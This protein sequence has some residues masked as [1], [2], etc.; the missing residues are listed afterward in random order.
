M[1]SRC[2]KHQAGQHTEV[3][4]GPVRTCS[5]TSRRPDGRS[6]RRR[7]GL[8]CAPAP[9]GQT[10][11][12][13]ARKPKPFRA[14]MRDNSSPRLNSTMPRRGLAPAPSLSGAGRT[15]QGRLRRRLRRKP[16]TE[17]ARQS[18]SSQLSGAGAGLSQEGLAGQP[19]L[20]RVRRRSAMTCPRSQ[21]CLER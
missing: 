17:P 10:A 21:R 5:T 8:A 11:G 6:R 12:R 4:R 3:H 15:R 1:R 20:P 7:G 13:L 18:R 16:L 19:R 14:A 9:A 2:V